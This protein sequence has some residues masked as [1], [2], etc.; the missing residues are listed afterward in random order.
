ML[1][2]VALHGAGELAAIYKRG[3]I[4]IDGWQHGLPAG[5]ENQHQ[6]YAAD[7]IWR[8]IKLVVAELLFIEHRQCV[9]FAHNRIITPAF[10]QH[11]CH[12]CLTGRVY[13]NQRLVLVVK[14]SL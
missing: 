13:P 7:N 9:L 1:A 5:T 2:R 12:Q 6:I 10:G 14:S 3:H 8:L 11:Q 4:L